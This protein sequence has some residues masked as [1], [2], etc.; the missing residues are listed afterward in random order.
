MGFQLDK[1]KDNDTQQKTKDEVTCMNGMFASQQGAPA[2]GADWVDIS[3][4]T[5]CRDNCQLIGM[6]FFP[7]RS[8]GKINRN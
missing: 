8:A 1:D 4:E 6:S 3:G 2:W 7:T 5:L